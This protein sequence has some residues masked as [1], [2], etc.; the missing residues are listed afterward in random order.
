MRGKKRYDDKG[1][2]SMALLENHRALVGWLISHYFVTEK[3]E[4]HLAL[5]ETE[6]GTERF[7]KCLCHFQNN[8][9]LDLGRAPGR[10]GWWQEIH[11]TF[12]PSSL[13]V[14][15]WRHKESIVFDVTRSGIGT[16]SFAIDTQRRFAVYVGDRG[17]D[18]IFL[19]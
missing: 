6:K 17:D 19:K 15:G 10:D 8:L 13:F 11:Q 3:Q 18:W 16:C 2:A 9:R 14:F 7:R 4:R 12:N 1:E 5:L